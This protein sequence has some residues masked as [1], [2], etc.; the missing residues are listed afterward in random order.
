MNL[1]INQINEHLYYINDEY[2]DSMYLILGEKRA[3]LIDTGMGKGDLSKE[4]KEITNLPIDVVL[5][6]AHIDHMY[7]VESFDKVYLHQKEK[8][9]WKWALWLC[10]FAGSKMYHVQHKKYPIKKMIAINEGHIFDLGTT[11]IKVINA[12]GH[13][14]GSIVLVDEGNRCVYLG[15]AVG[16][17]LFSWMWLPGSLCVSDYRESLIHLKQELLP[18]KDFTFYGGHHSQAFLEGAS[19]VTIDTI[20]DMIELCDLVLARKIQPIKKEK[21]MGIGIETYQYK[22][23]AF[24]IRQAKIK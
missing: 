19:I 22:K 7:H 4:L 5:T 10:V 14:P 21:M 16:S 20:D 1:E 9:A 8:D 17:G 24:V 23:A 15:D 13:T 12:F 11:K 3:L 18:Y 2:G 6:H